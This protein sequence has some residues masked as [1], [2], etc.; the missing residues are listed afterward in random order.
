MPTPNGPQFVNLVHYGEA[1]KPPHTVD[2]PMKDIYENNVWNKEDRRFTNDVIFMADEDNKDMSSAIDYAKYA[3]VYRV[4]S[5]SLSVEV[6]GDDDQP[7]KSLEL[8][9]QET[10]QP[11]LWA[12]VPASREDAVSRGRV[13]RYKNALEAPGSLSYIV[14][15][16]LIA[17]GDAQHLRS[18]D[19]YPDLPEEDD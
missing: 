1:P 19:M 9:R 7:D 14:P 5:K 10:Q 6:Y 11:E 13:V 18:Y 8:V 12:G 3:H 15:K 16:S 17:S 2:H 4:P